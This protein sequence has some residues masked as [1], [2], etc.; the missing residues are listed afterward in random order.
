MGSVCQDSWEKPSVPG[1][2]SL[3]LLHS[4]LRSCAALQLEREFRALAFHGQEMGWVGHSFISS[5]TASFLCSHSQWLILASVPSL[6]L[7]LFPGILFRFTDLV[8][9]SKV[10]S[11]YLQRTMIPFVN[12]MIY[13]ILSCTCVQ[14]DIL[15][16]YSNSSFLYFSP[17]YWSKIFWVICRVT[18]NTSGQHFQSVQPV[19]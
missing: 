1:H 11:L 10:L 5:R 12:L 9:L 19:V 8:H 17:S 14:W 13:F 4:G 15:E 18:I 16:A 3:V 2:A 7:F 6:K